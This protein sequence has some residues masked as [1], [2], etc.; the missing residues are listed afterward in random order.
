MPRHLFIISRETPHLAEYMRLS[1][2]SEPGVQVVIDRRSGR[3]R[4]TKATAVVLERRT[5][6]RRARPFVDRQLREYF[7]ALITIG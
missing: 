6:D 4:R 1:F 5:G 2:A 7:H 3:D